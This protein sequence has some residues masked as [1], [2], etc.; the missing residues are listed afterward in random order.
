MPFAVLA[1]APAASFLIGGAVAAV[2]ALLGASGALD[3]LSIVKEYANRREVLADAVT[4]HIVIVL[5]ALVPTV[6]LGVPLGV[7]AYR[8]KP[9]ADAAFPILNIVQTIPSIA[10][11][12][13]LMTPLS[14]LAALFRVSPHWES[15]AS[16]SPRR[17]IALIAYSLLPIVRNVVEGLAGVSPAAIE[18]A[19]GMGMTRARSSG[20][21]QLPLALPVFLSGSA[22]HHGSGRSGSRRWRP[23]RRRRP[24]RRHVPGPVRQR[25]GPDHARRR[26]GHSAGGDRGCAPQIWR[27]YT[28]KGG[29]DDRAR[30]RIEAL[31]QVRRPS[32]TSR[33]RIGKGEFFAVI[34]PSGSG[35][36]TTLK[37]I[38]R[39][40][41]SSAGLIRID[42]EDVRRFRPEDLRRRM[43]YV[44]QS[45]GLFPHWTVERNIVDG[46]R[47]SRLAEGEDQ[48][49]RDRAPDSAEARPGE[50]PPQ[51]SAPALRRAAAAR[52]R[53]TGARRKTATCCS[54]TS[55]SARSTR[56]RA[57]RCRRRW[58]ASMA[59]AGTTDRLRHP[60]HRR[61]AASWRRASRSWSRAASCR[62]ARRWSCSRRR[63]RI[64]CAISSAARITASGCF[65]W[66]RCRAACGAGETA[67]GEPIADSAS[68]RQALSQMISRGTDRLGVVDA[69]GRNLGVLQLADLARP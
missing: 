63:P 53:R 41:P 65:R 11:F 34:G 58:R 46:A 8:R 2:I 13:I 31:R 25:P 50:L 21:S 20:A 64:S 4:R 36:S 47:A 69:S 12:A 14:G 44:I 43:G 51:V 61:G 18:A 17:S 9:V 27:R 19:R 32:T 7:L 52:R 67:A 33:S 10:L 45:I 16:A 26:A 23:D 38:N 55:P 62:S 57:A 48:R 37:M 54:W 15:A 22:H 1:A 24:R 60:R 56:S 28:Q 29:P 30:P 39:L 40:I 35:K 3:Q 66:S 6:V 42:G 59:R 5:A 68:L 49:S